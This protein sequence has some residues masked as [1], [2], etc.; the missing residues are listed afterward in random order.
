MTESEDISALEAV[1]D[2]IDELIVDDELEQA[3]EALNDALEEYGDVEELLLLRAEIALDAEDYEVCIAAVDDA[4]KR[5]DSDEGRGQLL[6]LRGYAQF[7][8]DRLEAARSSF[9]EAIRTSGASWT[10]LLGRAM[11]HE[12]LLYFRAVM[13]DLERA[14]AMDDQEAQP[15]AIR[16]SI[17]LR[18][19]QLS[20]AEDE[21][22]H[23]LSLDPDDEESRLSLAR[24]QA[25]SQ[26]TSAAIETLEPLVE[27]GRDPELMLPALLL[28][29]QLSLTLGSTEAAEEDAQRA[30][31]LA[32]DRPWGHLQ[33]AASRLTA[34]RPGDAIAALK[35]A[36]STVDD[37][38]QIPDAFALRASAYDQLEKPQKAK[39]MRDKAEG[40]ARLPGVVYGDWLNPARNVPLNPN[41]P[42]DV[43]TLMEQIF[44]DPSQAPPG[45]EK[46]LREVIDRVPS[47]IEENPEANK[48]RI[49]LPE[50]EGAEEA[51]NSLVLQVTRPKEQA[52]SQE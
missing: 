45:Y 21:L 4:L 28:R 33:L 16:G 41:K 13:L 14:I 22:S 15:F 10:A 11:V 20:Q 3:Q 39:Q 5:V 47:M 46:A 51:P 40:A 49:Q 8:L 37:I 29:S 17:Y 26:K 19:G 31:D 34:M 52:G 24:L 18:R 23:A 1:I 44:D 32:P 9:N 50:V 48:I 38:Q 27:E 7:Y 36:E 30:V 43:R 35:E 2:E 12:E 25:T 6:E 42:I